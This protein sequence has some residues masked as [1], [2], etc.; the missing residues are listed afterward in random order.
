MRQYSEVFL[1]FVLG[2]KETP[3]VA[4]PEGIINATWQPVLGKLEDTTLTAIVDCIGI[5][6]EEDPLFLLDQLSQEIEEKQ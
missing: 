1:L 2:I 5:K 3:Q 4:I 6:Y